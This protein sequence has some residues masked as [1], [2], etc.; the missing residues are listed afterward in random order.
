MKR[1]SNVELTKEIEDKIIHS[2]ILGNSRKF[3]AQAA[4]IKEHY[5][6]KWVR[7]GEE[8]TDDT[9]E[10]Y[11]RFSDRLR[12]AEGIRV[13]NW[14]TIIEN[15]AKNGDWKAAAWKLERTYPEI[16]GRYTKVEHTGPEGGPIK[17]LIE[18]KQKIDITKLSMDELNDL[19][20]ILDKSSIS[21]NSIGEFGS[22]DEIAT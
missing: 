20:K 22:T 4:G 17:N 16:F 5:I 10:K 19:E 8:V 21:R 13:N 12:E 1:K 3:A 9:E 11:I 15:A 14:L 7:L 6:P 18:T 2:I